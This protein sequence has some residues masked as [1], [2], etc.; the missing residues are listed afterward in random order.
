MNE[1]RSYVSLARDLRSGKVTPRTYLEECLER[2]AKN[3]PRI[4]AFVCIN[5]EDARTAADA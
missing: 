5:A 4:G 1:L 2:I 3:E